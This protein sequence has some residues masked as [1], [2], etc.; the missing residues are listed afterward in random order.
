MLDS[1]PQLCES[2]ANILPLLRYFATVNPGLFSDFTRVFF[3]FSFILFFPL[4]KV[5]GK[6]DGNRDGKAVVYLLRNIVMR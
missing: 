5:G 4:G 3:S 6:V 1:H 2:Q